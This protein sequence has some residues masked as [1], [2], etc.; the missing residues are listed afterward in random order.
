M[1][2]FWTLSCLMFLT[3]GV[4][5][6]AQQRSYRV[7]RRATLEWSRYRE[8]AVQ[9]TVIR[10]ADRKRQPIAAEQKAE[11]AP[12]IYQ[13][14]ALSAPRLVRAFAGN[15]FEL[16]TPND[17]SLAVS[18]Y[19]EILSAVNSAVRVY[20]TTGQHL[21]MHTL[22]ALGDTLQLPGLEFDPRVWYDTAARRFII[23]FL[24]GFRSSNSQVIVGFSADSSALGAWHFY[25]LPGD[26]LQDSS[27][28]DFPMIT[29]EGSSLFITLNLLWNDST[30]QKGFRQSIIW[31]VPM[32][33]GFAGA[34]SL[35]A[36]LTWGVEY[37]GKP[38]RNVCPVI[39]RARSVSDSFQYYLSNRNFSPANDSFF[40]IRQSPSGMV[41]V[42]VFRTSG[43]Y[44][45]PPPAQ[46]QGSQVLAT[47]DARVLWAERWNGRIFFAGNTDD[48]AGRASIY[49][50]TH[51]LGDTARSWMRILPTERYEWG[52]P[53]ITAF[54]ASGGMQR[55]LFTNFT[56]DTTHPG[57]GA[58]LWVDTMLS[59]LTILHRGFAS[60]NLLRSDTERWGD[61]TTCQADPAHPGRLW[62]AG[63]VGRR[64]TQGF[65]TYNAH[66]TWMGAFGLSAPPAGLAEAPSRPAPVVMPQPAGD[67]AVVRVHIQKGGPYRAAVYDAGGR[68]VHT[69][70]KDIL[71][72]GTTYHFHLRTTQWP[73]GLYYLRLSGPD[74][75]QNIRWV[76]R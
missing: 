60:V 19:G 69:L 58:F 4:S 2:W 29:V 3:A 57:C 74:G 49:V 12:P 61:Y 48:G 59:E 73:P 34:D 20:D 7:P 47:N 64:V 22:T 38:L 50:G 41:T 44:A 46:M 21:G 65:Y 14:G 36:V 52:Y 55:L 43:D 62:C 27:W 75:V 8:P 35:D 1:K 23:V 66:V 54:P 32:A 67:H 25:A 30:W 26:P 56:A 42:S 11:V 9:M 31:R 5:L 40:L 10:E 18:H 15:P 68:L 37:G 6:Y 16:A 72:A 70:F 76:L 33:D 45:A 51:I 24:S 13:D 28:S 71:R 53:C 63:Y 17:N 39:T